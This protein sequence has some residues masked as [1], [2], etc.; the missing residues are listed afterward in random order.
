VDEQVVDTAIERLMTTLRL[1]ED[2]RQYAVEILPAED[3][4]AKMEAQ[5]TRLTGKLA[6]I[7]RLL[8]DGDI[9]QDE[10]RSEKARLERDLADLAL[11]PRRGDREQAAML[12]QSIG[13]LW[14]A[15][16]PAERHALATTVISAVYVDL[17]AGDVA[18]I[19]LQP[20]FAPLRELLPGVL[21]CEWPAES[22]THATPGAC[23]R[24]Q[25]WLGHRNAGAHEHRHGK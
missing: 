16:T 22:I 10:Y 13:P 20:A 1:P 24:E 9:D 7:K 21:G 4:A 23:K 11:L 12:L 8:L 25:A 3:A 6:H 19:E 14:E 15:A 17:D 18:A 5:R 2:W